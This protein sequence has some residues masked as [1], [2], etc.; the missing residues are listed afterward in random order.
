MQLVTL[1]LRLTLRIGKVTRG[2]V[3]NIIISFIIII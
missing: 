2:V 3:L 1:V